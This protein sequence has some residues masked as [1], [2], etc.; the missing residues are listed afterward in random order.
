LDN[1]SKLRA[2]DE[3]ESVFSRYLLAFATL[4]GPR[5][6]PAITRGR[7]SSALKLHKFPGKTPTAQWRAPEKAPAAFA[8]NHSQQTPAA[9]ALI[10]PVVR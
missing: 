7:Q 5:C 3:P 10:C 1:L 2:I 6:S 9:R 8:I 4:K